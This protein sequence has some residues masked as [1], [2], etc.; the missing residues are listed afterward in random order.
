MKPLLTTIVKIL[1]E[2]IRY[3]LRQ[4]SFT[5][6]YYYDLPKRRQILNQLLLIK[7]PGKSNIDYSPF[8]KDIHIAGCYNPKVSIIICVFNNLSYTLNC[9]Y[10]LSAFKNKVPFEVI[11]VDDCSTEENINDLKDICHLKYFRNT[12]NVGFLKSSNFGATKAKGEYLA[13]LNNDT[14]VCDYWLDNLIHYLESNKNE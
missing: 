14:V 11:L 5:I 7:K 4:L 9:L 12:K 8:I 2:P 6:K 10:S 13:F 3:I 1:P